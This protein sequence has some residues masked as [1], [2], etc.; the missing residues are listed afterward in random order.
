MMTFVDL[1]QEYVN[2]L[3]IK[4]LNFPKLIGGSSVEAPDSPLVGN[5]ASSF[6]FMRL[7]V[8]Y[9]RQRNG[10]MGPVRIYGTSTVEQ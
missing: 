2:K 7:R 10:L 9:D 3:L 8:E 6:F 1:L 5:T 4:F